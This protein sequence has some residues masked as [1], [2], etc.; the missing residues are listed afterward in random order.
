MAIMYTESY[1]AHHGVKGQKWGTRRYQNEDGSYK[2]GAEG[3][4]SGSS[5]G[6][7]NPKTKKSRNLVTKYKEYSDSWEKTSKYGDKMNEAWAEANAARKKLGKTAIGRTINAIKGKSDEAKEYNKLYDKASAMSDKYNKMV[8]ADQEKYKAMGK[9][10]LTRV[11]NSINSAKK[12]NY[13]EKKANK[14]KKLMDIDKHF[15]DTKSSDYKEE[16]RTYDAMKRL[17]TSD[18]DNMSYRQLKKYYKNA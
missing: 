8:A 11:L 4:Y 6:G 17:K 13:V 7:D 15:G 14:A 18:L 3:R 10:T 9:T 1:L 5:N 2:P 12:L 16:K